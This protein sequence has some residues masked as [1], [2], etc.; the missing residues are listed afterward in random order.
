M[1]WSEV[2]RAQI[3]QAV[4]LILDAIGENPKREGFR[5]AKACC[6]DV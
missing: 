3:E 5:Y 1:A 6:K 4:H 2:N